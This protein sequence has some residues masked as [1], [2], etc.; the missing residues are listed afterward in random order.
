[1][2]R[3][4]PGAFLHSLYR[5]YVGPVRDSR[6]V[7]AGF[8]LFFTGVGLVVVSIAVFLWSTTVSPSGTFKFVLRE[9]AV[10]AGAAGLPIVL[11]GVTVLLPVSR[12]IDAAA[13]FG[14]V[15]CLIAAVRFTQ[16]YP[17]AWYTYSSTVVG[18]YALG[19]VVVVATAGT[20]LSGY[21]VERATVRT[22]AELSGGSTS[23][24]SEA[25]AD[26]PEVT[27]EQVRRDIE[28]AMEGAEI[29]W[30]GVERDSGRTL[31]LTDSSLDD[32]DSV[33]LGNASAKESRGGSVDDAVAG[34]QSLRGG[35]KKTATSDSGTSDQVNA[36]AELR[37][38]QREREEAAA[39]DDADGVFDRLR[40]LFS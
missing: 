18:I 19:A 5:R 36:L 26:E 11:F 15:A 32:A 31:T 10:T 37:A 17:Q 38:Q 14:V 23:G 22:E 34:L 6:D 16:I 40:S 39:D 13:G 27:D 12:R 30:G 28:D 2:E 24:E 21:H 33:G 35:Q 4:G 8:G 9:F 1:M 3:T 25:A 20:A 29:N 7:Y